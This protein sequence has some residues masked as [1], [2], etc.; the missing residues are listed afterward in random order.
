MDKMLQWMLR[1]GQNVTVDVVNLDVTSRQRV[2][3]FPQGSPPRALSSVGRRSGQKSNLF[4]GASWR[5][6]YRVCGGSKGAA[7]PGRAKTSSPGRKTVLKP[8]R[9]SARKEGV[10]TSGSENKIRL[11]AERPPGRKPGGLPRQRGCQA[12]RPLPCRP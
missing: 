11:V 4:S 2:D 6:W 12:Q 7:E 1:L 3:S 9:G 5:D 8:S 10:E